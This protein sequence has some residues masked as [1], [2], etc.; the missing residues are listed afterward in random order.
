MDYTIND[1]GVITSVII[2]NRTIPCNIQTDDSWDL[3][4]SYNFNKMSNAPVISTL[5]FYDGKNPTSVYDKNGSLLK[6]LQAPIE[7]ESPASSLTFNNFTVYDGNLI[8]KDGDGNAVDSITDSSGT[9]YN[10]SSSLNIK[11][12]STITKYDYN[13]LLVKA[14]SEIYFDVIKGQ[15]VRI[16]AISGY[17]NIYVEDIQQD[18]YYKLYDII[19][20]GEFNIKF[21]SDVYLTN[22]DIISGYPEEQ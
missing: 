6:T 15:K 14:G 11:D 16:M 20:S 2:G 18:Q 19:N 5:E 13:Y 12:G 21:L 4:I 10:G 17:N 1:S 22:V 7:S 8:L 9:L 3:T